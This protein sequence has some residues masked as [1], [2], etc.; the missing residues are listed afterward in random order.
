MAGD[1]A[2]V[3]AFYAAFVGRVAKS[4]R[5]PEETVRALATGEI[6]LGEQ[7]RELGLVDEIG[8]LERAVALA[9]EAAGVPARSAPVRLRRPLL[10]RLAGCF[11]VSLAAAVADEIEARL[12]SRLRT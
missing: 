5:L 3:D 2:I 12:E 1:Q 11:G 9:A 7:A 8:D 6:W 4:R 10:E